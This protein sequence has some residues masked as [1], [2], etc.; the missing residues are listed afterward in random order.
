MFKAD[1]NIQLVSTP[2]NGGPA[3]AKNY[4]VKQS[5][6]KYIMFMDAGDTF[7]S[8]NIIYTLEK[9]IN[10]DPRLLFLST[11]FYEETEDHS[12]N[13]IDATNNTWRGKVYRKDFYERYHLH[14]LEESSFLNDDIG[15]NMLA[16]LVTCDYQICH[17]D[18]PAIIWQYNADSITRRNNYQYSYKGNNK[19][20]AAAATY[21][22]T[23]AEVFGVKPQRLDELKCSVL[24]GMFHNYIGTLHIQPQYAED[25]LLGAKEFYIKFFKDKNI[26]IHMLID[27]YNIT[28]LDRLQ[29][30]HW[31]ASVCKIPTITF[32]D[33]I[34]ALDE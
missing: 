14:F 22:L 5:T 24:C 9:T 1:L 28:L 29:E 16:R 17:L 21:A 34:R 33:F 27:L 4:G 15:M 30:Q 12:L 2:K 25:A 7:I 31:S 18:I 11:G 32:I 20:I 19:G 13:Y 26:D 6:N 10:Q 3:V 8:S 23:E